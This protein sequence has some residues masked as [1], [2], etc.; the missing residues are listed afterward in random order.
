M[1]ASLYE[2]YVTSF[3]LSPRQVIVLPIHA[4]WNDYC[5]TVRDR[6]HHEVFYADVDLGK[7]TFKK[8]V[9]NAQIAQY[10]F[11]LVC[12]EE[13]VKNNTVNIRTRENKVEGE[14]TVDEMVNMFKR[15]RDEYK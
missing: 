2:R 5:Q 10:N 12:G 11:I 3:W 4:D 8:K 13:E 14:L 15:L 6:L 9:A 7:N 1:F